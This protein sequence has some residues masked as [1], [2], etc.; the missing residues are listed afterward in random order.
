MKDSEWRGRDDA[1]TDDDDRY[2]KN[3]GAKRKSGMK[4]GGLG[5]VEGRSKICTNVKTANEKK[6][7]EFRTLSLKL[8][9]APPSITSNF[10]VS[11]LPLSAAQCS[12]VFPLIYR[13]R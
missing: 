2:K 9:L 12:G 1:D 5:G 11:V 4:T 7:D 3:I 6:I 10:V 13:Y 8:S